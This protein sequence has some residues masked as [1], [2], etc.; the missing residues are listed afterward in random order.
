MPGANK[1][2]RSWRREACCRT[3]SSHDGGGVRV[4]LTIESL[5]LDVGRALAPLERR[6][7]GGEIALLFAEIG[8]PSSDAV[9]GAQ[10]VQQAVAQAASALRELPGALGELA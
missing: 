8:L 10:A 1:A 7:R 5:M 6:L 4:A 2:S 9:L 3:S